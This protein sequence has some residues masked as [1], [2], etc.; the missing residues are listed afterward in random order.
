MDL[1]PR[2]GLS[3]QMGFSYATMARRYDVSPIRVD[4][5]DVTPKFVLVGLGSAWPA[6]DGL[7]AGTP[8]SE[9]RARVAFG[10]SHDQ[11]ERKALEDL[12]R[13]LTSG[14]GRYEN[15]AL[16]GRL[17]V[18][19]RDSVELAV[20]RRAES[21]TDLISVGD[22]NHAVSSSRSLSASRSDV[23]LMAPSVA[24]ARRRRRLSVG[25][26]PMA[27]TRRPGPSRTARATCSARTP[28]SAGGAGAGRCSCGEGMWGNLDVHRE[29]P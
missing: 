6:L 13:I 25:P 12:D 20:D 17:K 29:P 3:G 14:T 19:E 15:F 10:T 22:E 7:G 23:A 21:A 27:T 1:T 28:R 8:A 24:G 4:S 16:H 9:W 26:S 2:D 11:Q 5:S 18:A